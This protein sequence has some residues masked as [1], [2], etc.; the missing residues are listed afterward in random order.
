MSVNLFKT[1]RYVVVAMTISAW[2]IGWDS[3]SA[4]AQC[5]SQHGGHTGHKD[6]GSAGH[7]HG[8]AP[9]EHAGHDQPAPAPHGGQLTTLEPLSFEVVY[10]PQ[11]I[12]VYIYGPFPK[13]ASGKDVKGEISLQPR[14]DQ[15]AT[16]LT[17]RHVAPPERE[18]EYLSVPVD[19]SRVKDGE[20]TATIKLEN[21]PLPQHPTAT[22]TQ[23]VVLSKA[24]L[25]VVLAALDQNDRARIARQRVCPVT[26]AELDSMGGPIKVLVG[27]RPLYLCCKGCLGKVQNAPEA[28]LRKASPASQGQ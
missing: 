15:R 5:C 2:G 27:G 3:T 23:E 17:L 14:N 9:D 20:L 19:L 24:R 22:F 8:S 12:R 1:V 25:Q 28:Y 16:R 11:E 13:P 26:G 18:Q 21:V 7:Q 4:Y 6:S 10:Q